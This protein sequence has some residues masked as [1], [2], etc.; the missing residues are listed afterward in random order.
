MISLR[1]SQPM[2]VETLNTNTVVLAGPAG[3]VS[4]TVV[5]AEGGMLAFVNP[6]SELA[7]NT[8]YT[9]TVSGALGTSGVQM[10]NATIRFTTGSSG[11]GGGD[12]H[13][14]WDWTR[15]SGFAGARSMAPDQQLAH[16]FAALTLAIVARATCA[17]GRHSAR[18]PGADNRWFSAAR[19]HP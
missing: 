6:Q 19:R 14:S 3:S 15:Q 11:G 9:I 12:R 1:F 8:T 17:C 10:P 2:Q 4:T 18:G 13:R 16:E 5:P 7:P